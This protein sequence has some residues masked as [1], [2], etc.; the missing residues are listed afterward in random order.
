VKI[1]AGIVIDFDD[2]AQ[3]RKITGVPGVFGHARSFASG[4]DNRGA[5]HVDAIN[6]FRVS[7]G[8]FASFGVVSR[9]QIQRFR[10]SQG[11]LR[12]VRFPAA[13]LEGR[14]SDAAFF[15]RPIGDESSNKR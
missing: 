9:R 2:C 3:H 12:R 13:P 6:A 5:M 4:T 7:A 14:R 8:H 11:F 1:G 15:V 10:W